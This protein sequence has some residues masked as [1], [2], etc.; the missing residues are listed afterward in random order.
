MTHKQ[1][2]LAVLRGEPTDVMPW[3]PRLDLWYA[4]NHRAGT[5]PPQ[6]AGATLRDI[7]DDLDVGYHAIIPQ[8]KDLRNPADDLHRAL[9]I[10]NLWTMPCRTRLHNVEV[11]A[12]RQGDETRVTYRTPLGTVTT[13]VVY[14][15]A[16]RAAGISIT[17]ISEH[18]I[19]DVTDYAAVGYLFENAEV[20]PNPTGYAEFAD[21]V[22]DRGIAAGFLSLAASPMHLLQRELMPMELFF[23][24]LHDHPEAVAACAAS[25]GSYYERMFDVCAGSP[26]E[27]FLLGANYDA[28][29]T[30]RP[31]FTEHITPWLKAFAD[32]LHAAGKYLLTHTDGENAGLLDC[33]L[34]SGIDI[35]D[36]ICPA[37]MTKLTF[38]EVRD[39]FGSRIT[40]MGGIPSVCLLRD[41]MPDR[42]FEA[43][44]DRFFSDLDSG[45]R[46][47]LGISDTTP[48]AADFERLKSIGQRVRAFGAG[49]VKKGNR[50]E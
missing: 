48:P 24:E 11:T 27:V 36:S 23:Y 20:L 22:G 4:A 5:L 31:F 46:L 17:H 40:I 41:S 29:V 18:A 15:E 9:G 6:Y 45:D 21:Y 33:Y 49:P 3:A 2:M 50:R 1:R 16:M 35:A 47:I 14:D 25:I 12:E 26:V 39:H 30:F 13:A 32:R 28:G 37:P 43:Y 42:E 10:Y 7:T 34:E 8:F 19:K 38:K 44:L